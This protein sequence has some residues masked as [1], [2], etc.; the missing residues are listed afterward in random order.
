MLK[1]PSGFEPSKFQ[2]NFDAILV[3]LNNDSDVLR[4]K[5]EIFAVWHA[6]P[7]IQRVCVSQPHFLQQLL[8]N[9]QLNISYDLEDYRRLLSE[10]FLEAD[11]V[12]ALQKTLRRIRA[13]AYARIAWR[14]LQAYAGVQQTLTELSFFAEVCV[15]GA[16]Q[17]CFTWLQSR[18]DSND[19]VKTLQQNIVIFALGKLGG[20]ELNFSSDIDIVF[21]YS[22]E[23]EDNDMQQA[24]KAAEFYLKVVQLFIKVLSEQTQDGF[25][26]RVDTRLRPFGNSGTLIPS[27]SSVDQYFQAHGRDWE[28]YAWLKARVI[29]GDQHNGEQFLQ[30]VTPFVYRRYLDYGAME[31]LREMKDLIDVK[32]NQ[33]SAK[34]NLKIGFGGIREIEFIA[35]MFQLIYGGKDSSLRLRSTLRALQQLEV[36]GL[37]TPA[38]K[39]DLIEAYL[40]LRKA[41]NCLQLREDQQVHSLPVAEQQQIHFAYLMGMPSWNEFY[42]EYGRHT[43]KV[44]EIYQLLLKANDETESEGIELHGLKNVWLQL[45]EKEYCLEILARHFNTNAEPV[46]EQL[47]NFKKSSLVQQLVPVARSRL[48]SFVPIFLQQTMQVEDPFQVFKRFLNILKK[49]TQRSTYISLLI[50]NKDKLAKIFKLIDSSS[51]VSQ[52]LATHPLLLDEILRMDDEYEPPGIAEMQQQL[53]VSLGD[54]SDDL[55]K[56]MEGLREFKHAQAIQIAAADVVENYPIMKVSDH[57]SW[58]AETCI[59]SAVQYAYHELVKKYGEPQCNLDNKAYVPDVLIVEY[60]KLGGLE[61]G[62]G[63]DLDLVFLHN[64]MGEVCETV[65]DNK[66]HND[67]FFTR[68]VQRTIHILSTVTAGGKVFDT[69]LRLRPHGDSG[70]IISSVHAYENYLINDAWLWEHQALVRARAVT[71]SAK[72]DSE[73]VRIR[74]KVLCRI[75]QVEDVRASIIEMRNKMLAAKK[76]NSPDEFNIKQDAGGVIDI[77]F[78]VQF[79][80]L[81]YSHKHPEI[82]RYTDNVRILDD[83]AQAGLMEQQTVE[84]LK[85]IYLSY[86]K[87]LHQLSL[88][89]LPETVNISLFVAERDLVKTYWASL[90]HSDSG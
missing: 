54:C 25:V 49:I 1:L 15:K 6:S 2:Q 73:F 35:Q 67:M 31:S 62:Y 47:N 44:N 42:T 13:S 72:L 38:W 26:F 19:F 75:R 4:Y 48:D 68:L 89:L 9:D 59:N 20:G 58:L 29:A 77:E 84:E 41:E 40:F 74:Q 61:L 79:L 80:V 22:D 69:D 34:E 33:E 60:G 39:A 37:L 57:L 27:F 11:S 82:C 45:D 32:A 23:L 10:E 30:E 28:R 7:F 64:S 70:P 83:C 81:S 12:E 3:E 50:E 66:I 36:Q 71:S 87:Y 43:Y 56:Y 53:M 8:A 86:R 52:Y 14:D 17:W 90:L 24:G 85:E 5:D 76:S 65:G 55:E 51:W 18:S 63:S 46:Y 21:A 78:I 88:M 16:L